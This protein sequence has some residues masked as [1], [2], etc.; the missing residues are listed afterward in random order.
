MANS[1]NSKGARASAG[2][3]ADGSGEGYGSHPD[4]G[5]N[6]TATL[7]AMKQALD[8]AKENEVRFEA[9]AQAALCST[10]ICPS[11][12]A[13]MSCT[14]GCKQLVRFGAVTAATGAVAGGL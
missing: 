4:G 2:S 8:Q 1:C 9:H 3:T 6:N 14:R 11:A 5:G 7:A 12:C 13:Y 10:C